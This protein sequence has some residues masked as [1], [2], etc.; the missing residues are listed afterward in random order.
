MTEGQVLIRLGDSQPAEAAVAAA[1][2]ELT[3]AQQAM[4]ALLRTAAL[5]Q[6]QAFLAYHQRP[7]GKRLTLNS[8]GTA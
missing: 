4:D 2:L 1:N 5:N 3:S 6:A 8:Y 7:K